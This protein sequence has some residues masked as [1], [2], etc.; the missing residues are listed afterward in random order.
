[1]DCL[2]AEGG[3]LLA[4]SKPYGGQFAG[5]KR[6]SFADYVRAI[7]KGNVPDPKAHVQVT[8]GKCTVS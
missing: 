5:A 4:G 3:E 7:L 6:P 2:I 1:M 8:G